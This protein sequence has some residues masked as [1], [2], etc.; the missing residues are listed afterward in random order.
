MAGNR[1]EMQREQV[2]E[3]PMPEISQAPW[4]NAT[5]ILAD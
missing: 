5:G 3:N 4:R 1:L 2:A